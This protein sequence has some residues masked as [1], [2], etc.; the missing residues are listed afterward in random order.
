M[1]KTIFGIS[2]F[3]FW[4]VATAIFAG[5]SKQLENKSASAATHNSTNNPVVEHQQTT[6]PT[7]SLSESKSPVSSAKT[8][9][10]ASRNIENNTGN[11]TSDNQNSDNS[12]VEDTPTDTPTPT[13]VPT[14]TPTPLPQFS[15]VTPTPEPIPTPIP[16]VNNIALTA[17]EVAKHNS[18]AS[19]WMIISG[20]VYDVTT[21]VNSHPGGVQ[22]ILSGCGQ[23]A[24][25]AF[26]AVHNSAGFAA[27]VSF[28]IGDLNQLIPAQ[29]NN[30]TI[31][32]TQP[33]PA[34][35]PTQTPA[36]RRSN[37]DDGG[38]DD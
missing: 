18:A 14:P 1:K 22:Q 24:T 13:P 34:P 11:Q 6:Q 30:Q 33:T 38:F 19:C 29:Q 17:T 20:K 28:Y 3:V 36:T 25:A 37:N 10:V 21:Y 4:V 31:T 35:S 12:L 15:I 23:D 16:T 9:T 26:D 32:T 2:F 7:A 27:L 8:K 5:N